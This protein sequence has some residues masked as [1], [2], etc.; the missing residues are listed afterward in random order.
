[1]RGIFRYR[2]KD[3]GCTLTGGNPRYPLEVAAAVFPGSQRP[4]IPAGISRKDRLKSSGR[5][6]DLF[7]PEKM[8][9]LTSII[10]DMDNTLFDLVSAK[11]QACRAV[12]DLLGSGTAEE[13]FSYFLRRQGGFEDPENIRDFLQDQACCDPDIYPRSVSLFREVQ[14][15]HIE[16]YP[17]VEQTLGQLQ[18]Q[19]YRI[20][21]VTDAH[22]P[23]AMARLEKAGLAR[24]F[25]PVVTFE[26]TGA[27]KP[28]TL[29][30]LCALLRM[31]S[32]ARETLLVGDS[33]RRDIAPGTVLGMQTVY[34]R[35]GDR[36][37][38]PTRDGGADH[39]ID[40]FADLLS[41]VGLDSPAADLRRFIGQV[42]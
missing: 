16:P 39:A 30:F 18:L 23:N 8:S 10:F 14:L 20:G 3:Q 1:V 6:G 33:P 42:D 29:P 38:R 22:Q 17:G 35:Y 28:S 26:M 37:S 9:P 34:A 11:M 31:G 24:F 19:G 15:E 32:M 40:R 41:I 5:E 36:F 21:L 4:F 13:L 25:D 27:H 12:T 7:M 2:V